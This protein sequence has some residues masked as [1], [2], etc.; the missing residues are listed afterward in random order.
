MFSAGHV[1]PNSKEVDVVEML[2]LTNIPKSSILNFIW[3]ITLIVHVHAISLGQ[4]WQRTKVGPKT[5]FAVNELRQHTPMG[6]RF[7]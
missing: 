3:H 6:F 2:F 4:K 7:F 1:H 5:N